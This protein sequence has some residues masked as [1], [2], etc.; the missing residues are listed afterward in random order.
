MG[1]NSP[2]RDS[3]PSSSSA[4]LILTH[5]TTNE[6]ISTWTLNSKNWGSA[7]GLSSYLERENYLLTVPLA[8]DSGITHWILTLSSSPPDSRPIFASCESLRKHA[9]VR[10]PN[11]NI[12]DV[13]THG[14]GS[15]FCDPQYRGKGYAGRMMKDLGPILKGWQA[16]SKPCAFSILYSDIGKKF[17]AGHG[18]K[19]FPSTHIAFP[20][21]ALPPSANTTLKALINSDLPNL[22]ALDEK[23]IRKE[24]ANAQDSKTHV[25]LVPD[26]DTMQWHH[27]REDFLTKKLFNR[28]PSIKGAIAISG[29]SRIWAIWTRSYYGP[30]DSSSSGNTLH[31]LRLVIENQDDVENN[32]KGLK[33]IIQLAQKE[34]QEWRLKHVEL[35]NPT[36]YVK[37]LIEKTGLEHSDVEREEESIASL[38]WYGDDK[39]EVVWVGNEK[40]GWC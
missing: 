37:N 35:W 38:M 39:D 32:I 11:G 24:L 12:K 21:S 34:A 16:E 25:A 27:L 15:V 26:C 1:S 31:I 2:P 17:Y 40:Y 29:L 9:L 14:I 8:R 36:S 6:R 10:G 33:G 3:L 30:I 13:I 28:S 22:C 4:E 5:P 23:Y 7:L 19:P 20:P 18:W